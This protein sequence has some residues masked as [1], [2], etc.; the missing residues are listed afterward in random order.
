MKKK[1]TLNFGDSQ[2]I[3][4]EYVMKVLPVII[5][6]VCFIYLFFFLAHIEIRDERVISNCGAI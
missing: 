2:Q 3:K 1:H 6:A 4:T 5:T